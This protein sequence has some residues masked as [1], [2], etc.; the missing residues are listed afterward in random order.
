MHEIWSL[1]KSEIVPALCVN[2]AIFNH[3]DP[4]VVHQNI[5]IPNLIPNLPKLKGESD[6]RK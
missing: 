1:K 4:G 2:F 3:H 5:N 6:L